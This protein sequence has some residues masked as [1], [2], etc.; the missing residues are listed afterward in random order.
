MARRLATILH[1]HALVNVLFV[2][3]P[4]V[5]HSY[6]RWCDDDCNYEYD[7]CDSQKFHL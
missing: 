4:K 7:D 5:S 1:A 6:S 3:S 2:N